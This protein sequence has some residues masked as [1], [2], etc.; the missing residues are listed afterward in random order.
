MRKGARELCRIA[1][2]TAILAVCAWISLPVG[3]IPVTLQTLGV[4][5]VAGVFKAKRAFFAVAAYLLL[6]LVGVPVFSGFRGGVSVFFEPTGG[7]LLGFLLFAPVVGWLCKGGFWQRFLAMLFGL[8]LLYAVGTVWF[9]TLTSGAELSG[10]AAALSVCVL[11]FLPFD[12]AKLLLAAY[13]S[14]RLKNI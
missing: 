6:G 14:E 10:F 1:A 5:L 7:F 2:A 9:A 3:A 11:P 8:V 12:I 4:C 13:L